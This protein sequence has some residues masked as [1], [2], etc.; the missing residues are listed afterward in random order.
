M[1]IALNDPCS[2]LNELRVA[3]YS[4]LVGRQSAQVRDGDRWQTFHRGDAKTLKA[5]IDRL[6]VQCDPRLSRARAIRVGPR[7]PSHGF[8]Y[9]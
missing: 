1:P 8:R 2:M 7:I 4:L 6:E 9:R 3:Y 5:E